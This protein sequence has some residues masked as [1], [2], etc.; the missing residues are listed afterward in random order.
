YF[1]IDTGPGQE[2]AGNDELLELLRA[3]ETVSQHVRE[4][5]A[6][7]NRSGDAKVHIWSWDW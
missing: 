5:H 4:R 1:A 3:D 6:R 7:P 2:R